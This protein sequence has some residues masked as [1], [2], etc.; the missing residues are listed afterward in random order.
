MTENA[1][2][3][4]EKNP[5]SVNTQLGGGTPNP[6]IPSP[7]SVQL[8]QLQAHLTLQRLK[9]AQTAVSSNTAAATVLNQVLSKVAM[10]QSLFNPLR[11]PSM[12]STPHVPAGATQL[13]PGMSST[14][15]PASGMSFSPQ[16]PA[17]VP[18][19]GVGL[20]C[21]GNIQNPN[22]NTIPI[23]PFGNIMP[24][25]SSQQATC[26]GF[27]KPGPSNPSGGFQDYNKI[28]TSSN[29]MYASDAGQFNQHGFMSGVVNIQNPNIVLGKP[30]EGHYTSPSQSKPINQPGFQ[31][32]YFVPHPQGQQVSVVRSSVLPSEQHISN[33][34]HANPKTEMIVP[35]I[36]GASMNNQWK[37]SF[38]VSS[39]NKAELLSNS[40]NA[41]PP[42]SQQYPHG[43][44]MYNP[45]EPT[46]DSKLTFVAPPPFSRLGTNNQGV[47]GPATNQCEDQ[48]QD[49]SNLPVSHLQPQEF[50]DFHGLTPPYLPH[51]CSIC[52]KRIFNL[53]DWDQHIKGKLH[54][55]KCMLFSESS[56][57]GST[58]FSKSTEG[59]LNPSINTTTVFD[60]TGNEDYSSGISTNT[61]NMLAAPSRPFTQSICGFSNHPSGSK[62]PQRRPPPGRVVHIC[63]LPE[64]SCTENDVI[65]LGLPFGKVTNYIL[66]RSTH[67]AF[68]EM[69]YTEAAQAMVQYY[70]QKPA[71]IN[72]EKLL[73]RMSKR[74]RELKPKKPGKNVESIIHDIHSQ[75]ERDL[76]QD[77]DRYPTERPRSRSPINRSLSPR[78]HSPS[79]SSSHSPLGTTRSEWS[80]G[81]SDRRDSWDWS[82]HTRREEDRDENVWRNNGE[83]ERDRSDL[84]IQDRKLYGRQAEKPSPKSTDDRTEG[85]R[86]HRDKYLKAN[87]PNT[88]HSSSFYKSRDDEYYRKESKHKSEKTPKQLAE[89]SKRKDSESYSRLR[90]SKHSN[91]EDA[92]RGETHE[93]RSNKALED[94]R[95]KHTEK[96]KS[97]KNTS[98]HADHKENKASDSEVDQ[99]EQ[100]LKE[101]SVSPSRNNKGSLDPDNGCHT[102]NQV[103]TEELWESGSDIEG[104]TWYPSNM[105]ELVTVDEVGEEEDYVMEPDLNELEE[106]ESAQSEE[107][108]KEV[109]EKESLGVDALEPE[110]NFSNHIKDGC[111]TT[112]KDS[113]QTYIKTTSDG[114]TNPTSLPHVNCHEPVLSQ[115]T[116]C[117]RQDPDLRDPK[118]P[119]A[120]EEEGE[121]YNLQSEPKKHY[122][123][124]D[125][126]SVEDPH[127][128]KNIS[129]DKESHTT[130]NWDDKQLRITEKDTSDEIK[131]SKEKDTNDET[132]D[133]NEKV[134]TDENKDSKET[135]EKE[136]PKAYPQVLRDCSEQISKKPQPSSP[137]E[138]ED[139]FSNFTIPLGVEF[140]VPRT[141]FYCKLCGIFYANEEMA[142]I[143][144]CR[145]TT[146]YRNLQKYLSQLAEESPKKEESDKTVIEE[147]TGIVPQ[148]EKNF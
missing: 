82:P 2:K 37:C 86:V 13:G 105:E 58:N 104:E 29:Q 81:L 33:F 30:S 115:S 8:A 11:P 113:I 43:N 84:W 89:H 80:N 60:P 19:V 100:S 56:A 92:A 147:D 6:L 126:S 42:A 103:P 85:T 93:R 45:E 16:N 66:M 118:E 137:W 40:N 9:L 116:E 142:K 129:E 122:E 10:S 49:S 3:L 79:C 133:S 132:K 50:S 87:P 146:H 140:V 141:G 41:W 83:Q 14:R 73:I 124:T 78:S 36:H 62:L 119:E 51:V 99:E 54:I 144:H 55:Q 109:P 114:E 101:S 25:T 24:Q 108:C 128:E 65:N 88:V 48:A 125:S 1:A 34:Q 39:Q 136:N 18:L 71:M 74:Y 138:R 95:S 21:S 53:K 59:T 139:V 148:F 98:H 135:H 67:Q 120:V 47:P 64:G 38:N 96:R 134:I 28:N 107:K 46:P 27:S 102:K 7:A 52:D 123:I 77:M 44:E 76:L 75:K 90:E 26:M 130:T 143:A 110:T 15:F 20:G 70:Q 61:T 97:K 5:F 23:S 117:K 69:A 32:D 63:N 68:L 145:S 35:V 22:P 94:T 112:H 131:D 91:S 127:Q 4:L 121:K 111:K 31:R 12:I 106:T 57:S 72:E 17:L